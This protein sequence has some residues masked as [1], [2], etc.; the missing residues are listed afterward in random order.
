MK[1]SVRVHDLKQ[2]LIDDGSVGFSINEFQL[3]LSAVDN[4]GNIC[5]VDE[6]LPLHLYAVGDNTIFG[7]TTDKIRIHLVTQR[8]GHWFKQFPRS[9]TI[10]Q[11]KKA[12]MS[13]NHFFTIDP[14]YATF[15][16]PTLLTDILLFRK[17]CDSYSKLDDD[18]APIGAKLS[19]NDVVHFIEERFFNSWQMIAV[20][21]QNK[22]IGIVGWS[23]QNDLNNE[24]AL[25][26]KL[27]VQ[28]Q[29]GFPVSRVDVMY[30]GKLMGNKQNIK[31]IEGL[32]IEVS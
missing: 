5:L 23:K 1:S 31:Y 32:R 11:M 22:D 29:L 17:H 18:E 19:N 2:Q 24:T 7:I 16:D 25:S 12:I 27:R 20:Y 10:N 14:N 28:D 21:Y 30:D 9:M 8:G 6:S 26:V 3:I 13:V 15:D 4:H